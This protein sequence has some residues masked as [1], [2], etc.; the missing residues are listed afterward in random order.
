[1]NRP[2][3]ILLPLLLAAAGVY[4]LVLVKDDLLPFLLAA[5][6]A[7]LLNPLVAFLEVQGLR[8]TAVVA[9]VYLALFAAAGIGASYGIS[10]VSRQVSRLKAEAPLLV[11][12]GQDVL[13]DV[14]E[15]QTGGI[16]WSS[17]R[18]RRFQVLRRVPGLEPLA[19]Y[20]ADNWQAWAGAYIPTISS[21]ALLAVPIIELSVLVPFIAFFFM[22]G[23]PSALNAVLD[24]VPAAYVEMVLNIL[25]EADNSLGNYLRSLILESLGVAAIALGGF[26]LIGLEYA[27][28][29]ALWVGL[30]N[31]IPYLGPPLGGLPAAAVVIL[32]GQGLEGVLKVTAVLSGVQF[33]D[34]WG[35]QP[36]LMDSMVDLHPILVLF[37]LMAGEELGGFWGIIFAVPAACIVKV[38]LRVGWEWY[39]SEFGIR[40]PPLPDEARTLPP[41]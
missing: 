4:F 6:L 24:L 38:V 40:P 33:I 29:I 14:R 7:Y 11:R 19:L 28:P 32:Q 2:A 30:T 41:I 1:M 3:K 37:A 25:V 20:A 21:W 27:F 8:R 23:G 16:Q 35:L 34:N 26:W 22:A 18:L 12:R 10:A 17:P 13:K 15:I 36:L 5:A 9:A 31:A 39:R